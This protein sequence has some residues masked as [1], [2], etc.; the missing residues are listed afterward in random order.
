MKQP[1]KATKA[2]VTSALVLVTAAGVVWKVWDYYNNPWTR[3]GRVMAQVIQISPRVS[4]WLVDLPIVDNQFVNQCDMLFQIDPRTFESTLKGMKGM[5]AE[6]EDEIE[7]LTAQVQATR[8]T[9][10]Q[11]DAAIKRAEQKMKGKEARL[12]DYRLQLQ[13]YAQLVKTGAASQER[14]DQAE[15][16]VIDAESVVAAARAELERAEA[17]KLQ[18]EA[19][20]AR[21]IANRGA[22]GKDNAR[23]KTAKARVHSAELR[24]EFTTVVAPVDGYVTHLNL[25]LGDQAVENKPILALVDVDSYWV[26]AYFKE[27]YVSDF[28]VGDRALV[29]LM[30]YANRPLEGRVAGIGWGIF[31]EDGST[32]QQLLPKISAAYKWIRQ[33]QRVPVRIEFESVPDDIRLVVGTTATAQV[34]TGTSNGYV[35]KPPTEVLEGDN[36]M[37]RCAAKYGY[38]H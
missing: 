10:K 21:D 11:Y 16:D 5:L 14:V 2:L 34:F 36:V 6:T 38:G 25:R 23:R 8:K 31:K 13:R 24:V 7:A 29:T 12:V 27:F 9:I 37:E 3:N 4:G 18:A 17:T 33:P 26:Y 30:G 32:A 1:S 15:A 28:Q 19:N 35:P 22:L 20:L